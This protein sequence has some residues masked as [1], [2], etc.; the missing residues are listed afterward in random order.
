M[1]RRPVLLEDPTTAFARTTPRMTP[2]ST[3][4]PEAEGDRGRREQDVDERLVELEQEGDERAGGRGRGSGRSGRTGRPAGDLVEGQARPPVG[5]QSG[6]HLLGSQGVP[7]PVVSGWRGMEIV[8]PGA[9]PEAASNFGAGRRSCCEFR[10]SVHRDRRVRY[11]PG[12]VVG[13]DR[14]RPRRDSWA[15]RGHIYRLRPQVGGLETSDAG[16]GRLLA[17]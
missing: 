12:G 9:E 4:S 17:R 14:P 13:R 6:R 16:C 8:Y 2:A 15:G 3:Y 10:Q 5:P 1:A 11:A 7:V